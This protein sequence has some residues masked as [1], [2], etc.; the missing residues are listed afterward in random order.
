MV[1]V[2]AFKYNTNPFLEVLMQ[3]TMV[4][5][6][7]LLSFDVDG[8]VHTSK[9]Q[10]R[11]ITETRTKGS[12]DVVP[13]GSQ[14]A[15]IGNDTFLY[16][17]NPTGVVLVNELVCYR[18]A[19]W[20]PGEVKPSSG[21]GK[22]IVEALYLFGAITRDQY[23]T[24]K[25]AIKAGE[26]EEAEKSSYDTLIH[27]LQSAVRNRGTSN[28]RAMLDEAILGIPEKERA[29][30]AARVTGLPAAGFESAATE[31]PKK[32]EKVARKQTPHMKKAAKPQAKKTLPASQAGLN[33]AVQLDTMTA[34]GKA[35]VE[36]AVGT[37][38]AKP[39]A[40]PKATKA[41]KTGVKASTPLI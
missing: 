21:F 26:A 15:I 10:I 17:R 11:I 14:L 35:K 30:I 22:A 13:N 25:K 8:K 36:A 31:K 2:V 34:E 39:D 37:L 3:R 1:P 12:V 16:K 23:H 20:I 32:A 18:S 33:R 5:D 19:G 9:R 41:R 4:K 28:V 27:T 24:H 7:S 29:K 40:K 38:T 6:Y